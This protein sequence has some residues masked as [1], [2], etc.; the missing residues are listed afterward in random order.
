LVRRKNT[1]EK[2]KSLLDFAR[3][4]GSLVDLTGWPDFARFLLR[5]I[6]YFTRTGLAIGSLGSGI[7]PSGRSRFNNYGWYNQDNKVYY[8][9]K[10]L[11]IKNNITMKK[12]LKYLIFSHSSFTFQ[13]VR[14][15]NNNTELKNKNKKNIFYTFKLTRLNNTEN[16][17]YI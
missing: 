11:K 15:K 1:F 12:N 10:Y 17:S 14:M 4:P 3:S 2:K 16:V 7:N 9:L 6:F 8:K 13:K 5:P